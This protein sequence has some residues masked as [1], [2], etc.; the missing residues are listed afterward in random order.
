MRT[1]LLYIL[2]KV[3][4]FIL[5]NYFILIVTFILSYMHRSKFVVICKQYYNIYK[6]R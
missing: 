5:F 1:W 2:M 6:K 3:S 4:Y